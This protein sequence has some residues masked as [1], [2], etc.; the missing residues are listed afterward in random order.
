MMDSVMVRVEGMSE[1]EHKLIEMK[2]NRILPDIVK[3]VRVDT[4]TRE[5]YLE[6]V[7]YNAAKQAM[8]SLYLFC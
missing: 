7:D 5:R 1:L 6:R 2:L 3:E 8:N 4:E